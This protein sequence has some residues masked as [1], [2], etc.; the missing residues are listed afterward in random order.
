MDD[1]A[2]KMHAEHFSKMSPK[3]ILASAMWG[4][5]LADGVDA[6]MLPTL[7]LDDPPDSPQASP[8]P[9]EDNKQS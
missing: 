3:L 4:L 7:P 1:E 6:S 5:M 8:A 2:Y 9:P